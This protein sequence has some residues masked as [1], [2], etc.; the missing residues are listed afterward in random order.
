MRKNKKNTSFG[1]NVGTSSLLLVFVIL[2]LV[3]F[4]TL[5]IVSANADKKLSTKVS[6]RSSEYYLACNQ[7]EEKLMN[8]DK[9]LK[10]LY[11]SGLS[12]N[13]FLEQAGNNIDFAIPV[14]DMQTLHI[15]ADI[16]YPSNDGDSFI[17]IKKWQLETTGTLELDE[18]LNLLPF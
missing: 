3:S 17:C 8:I 14:S 9:T 11:D 12:R 2:C 13:E 16:Q 6:D 15:V 18:S 10:D 1:V 4:A 7:A 5:S